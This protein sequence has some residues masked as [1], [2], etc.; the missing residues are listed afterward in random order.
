MHHG[1]NPA[2]V[3][4]RSGPRAGQRSGIAGSLA[5][6]R[7]SP[8]RWRPARESRAL[9]RGSPTRSLEA[10]GAERGARARA[11]GPLDP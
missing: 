8:S 5:V 9:G 2:A 11:I 7:G 1:T 4:L 3:E 6:G 10:A